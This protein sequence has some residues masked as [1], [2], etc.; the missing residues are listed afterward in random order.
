MTAG[1][2]LVVDDNAEMR[3]LVR[4]TL[5]PD[6]HTLYEVETGD[7]CLPAVLRL[8][9]DLV[10]LDVMTPGAKNGFEACA[11]IKGGKVP[12][13]PLVLLLSARGQQTDFAMGRDAGA[14]AYVTKPFSPR[15]LAATIRQLLSKRQ[16]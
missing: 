10:I 15:E 4:L 11:E 5:E 9:P 1:R 7:E 13:A 2:I 16:S 14:D 8:R 6:G 3:K 12:A